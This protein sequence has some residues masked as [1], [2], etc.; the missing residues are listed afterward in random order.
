MLHKK[1]E[2]GQAMVEFAL[3]LPIFVLLLFGMIEF[4]HYFSQSISVA[5]AASEGA[6]EGI[7]CASSSDFTSRVNARVQRVAPN[8]KPAN[9]SVSAVKSSS[10]GD[11]EVVVLI[12][13]TARTLTPVGMVIWGSDYHIKGS[14]TM[15]IG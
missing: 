11:D 12:D 1:R 6:R 10:S 8:L 14:C 2:S 15:K 5:T 3:F 9:L 7:V 13:Y 4:G